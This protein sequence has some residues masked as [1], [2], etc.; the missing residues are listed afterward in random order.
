MNKSDMDDKMFCLYELGK[1][2]EAFSLPNLFEYFKEIDGHPEILSLLEEKVKDEKYFETKYFPDILEMRFYRLALYTI[3]RSLAPLTIVE[4][5]VHHG[6]LTSF[7]L[8][9]IERNRKG[10]LY[11]IDLPSYFN[12]EIANQDGCLGFLPPNREPGWVVPDKLLQNWTLLKGSSFDLLPQLCNDLDN[13]D[14]F[15]HDSDHTPEVMHFEFNAVWEHLKPNG[16]LIADNIDFNPAFFEF[17][18]KVDYK[19]ILV[20]PY[21]TAGLCKRIRFG[22]LQKV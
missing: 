10:K 14:V 20:L 2:S 21:C 12:K 6:L 19:N 15:I 1:I 7:L 17:S 8:E 4:T 9:A 11:S 16:L 22:I 13:I 5:G 18:K 3:I